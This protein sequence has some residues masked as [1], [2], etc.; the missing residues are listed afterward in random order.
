MHELQVNH[1]S[2]GG[3]YHKVKEQAIDHKGEGLFN[4]V[5]WENIRAKIQGK[6]NYDLDNTHRREGKSPAKSMDHE[7]NTDNLENYKVSLGRKQRNK[8]QGTVG[9]QKQAKTK[10]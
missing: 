7:D 10:K 8:R 4:S 3:H 5:E 6:Y 1:S 9:T 2:I